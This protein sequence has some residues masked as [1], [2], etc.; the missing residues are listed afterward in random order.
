MSV[1]VGKDAPDFAAKAYH[2]GSIRKIRLIDY[3]GRW[4]ILF[5][6]PA[7]FTYV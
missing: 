2:Q 3:R 6:Y 7:D 4:V 1:S 5:F